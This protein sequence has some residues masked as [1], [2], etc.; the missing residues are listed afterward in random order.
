MSV[1]RYTLDRD[2]N[3]VSK[4][5]GKPMKTAGD[6]VPTPQLVRDTAPYTSP[7]TGRTVD[8]RRARRD[9]L[10]R[11]GSREVDPSEF[12]VTYESKERAIRNGG[13]WEPRK[14]VDLGNGYRRGGVS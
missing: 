2:G 9:D 11:S 7:I 6:F 3:W 13:E 10:A 14:A 1:D 8:G 5:T 12:K 4:A